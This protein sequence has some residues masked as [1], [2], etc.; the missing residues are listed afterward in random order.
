[1]NTTEQFACLDC[2]NDFP[3]SEGILTDNQGHQE[4]ICNPCSTKSACGACGELSNPNSHNCSEETQL[5]TCA[6]C[7]TDFSPFSEGYISNSPH[8]GGTCAFCGEC[9]K[10]EFI[11][12]NA[13][14]N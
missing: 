9:W 6:N 3:K 5:V 10:V 13:R 7:L 8:L 4:F 1:M 2:Y 14:S 11:R 12:R